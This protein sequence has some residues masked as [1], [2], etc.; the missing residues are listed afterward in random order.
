MPT[1]AMVFQGYLCKH[2]DPLVEDLIKRELK[3]PIARKLMAEKA[4]E[5]VW[6]KLQDN[7]LIGIFF[8]DSADIDASF[9]KWL[10]NFMPKFPL[11]R[12]ES[13]GD[14]PLITSFEESTEAQ[15]MF[16]SFE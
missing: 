12:E 7:S 16:V 5:M 8:N 13:T 6:A 9:E 10:G 4:F 3:H 1:L 2:N 14:Q 15:P 11:H